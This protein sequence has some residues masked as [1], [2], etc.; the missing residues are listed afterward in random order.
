MI[1][2]PLAIHGGPPAFPEGPPKWPLEDEE[3][4]AALQ[5]AYADRSWGAYRGPNGTALVEQLSAFHGVEFVTL[6]CS[7]TFAV[8]LALRALRIGPG[9][10]VILAGYDFPGNFRAVEATGAMPVL[11]EIDPDTWCLDP[12]PLVQGVGE[13]VRAILVSHLHGGLAPMREIMALA[14]ERGLA[15]VE[16]ACQAP[17]AMVQGRMA[18]TWGDVGVLSFGGSKLL[19]AGRGGAIVTGRA[20]LH[21]RA[22]IYCERGNNAFP[23]SELQAAILC[24]QLARLHERNASRRA[25]AERVLARLS[26]VPGLRPLTNRATPAEP[27]YYKMA[28]WYAP[29]EVGGCPR[30]EF[31]AAARAEGLALDVG[32]P[33]FVRRTPRRCGKLG[34]LSHSSLAA[35]ATVVLHHPVLLETPEVMDRLAAAIE[36]VIRGL[37]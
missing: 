8:E 24:P 26:G 34:D 3:V 16:D 2:E 17:G 18:G 5:R 4:L 21:Q 12:T 32:F 11:A 37:A 28:W 6:C 35:A 23:M 36:K 25:N 13:A 20:D 29:E 27:S 30:E 14:A 19:S 7:G 15:V 31:V 33:G 1:L 9:D 10:E 22:K